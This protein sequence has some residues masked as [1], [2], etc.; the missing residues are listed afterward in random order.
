MVSRN[1]PYIIV[2][3]ASSSVQMIPSER[4]LLEGWL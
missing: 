4:D 2:F 1:L 3:R